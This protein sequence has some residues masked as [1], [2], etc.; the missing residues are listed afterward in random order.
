[1]S[2]EI[3]EIFHQ[4]RGIL[5]PIFQEIEKLPQTKKVLFEE[6]LIIQSLT[7]DLA[8]RNK[9]SKNDA[10][11]KVRKAVAAFM[12]ILTHNLLCENQDIEDVR[13]LLI[14]SLNESL[15]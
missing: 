12:G 6:N 8:R 13:K 1:M 2:I 14:Q 3:S 11:M 5:K 7:L 10:Q 9:W 15:S 4:R